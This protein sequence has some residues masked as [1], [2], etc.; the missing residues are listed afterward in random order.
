[1]I[2]ELLAILTAF[3]W[4]IGAI[5]ARKGLE[6]SN[7]TSATLIRLAIG[8]AIYWALII[9]FIPLD[10]FASEAVIYHIIAGVL[11]GF[12]GMQLSYI[13]M[14]RYGVSKSSTVLSTQSVF[15]SF[16]AVLILGEILT[17]PIGVGTILIILGVALLSF[18][19]NEKGGWL[20]RRLIFPLATAFFYGI[21][22][23]PTK[24]GVDITNSPILGATI[25]SSTSLIVIVLYIFL[26]KQKLSLNRQSFTY[27]SL[28]GV[29]GSI[30]FLCLLYAFSIGNLVTV[31][32]LFSISPLFTILLA[33]F[34]LGGLEKITVKLIVSAILV[35]IGSAII[36]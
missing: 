5:C 25:E 19:R 20:D 24:I 2:A 22:S 30:A 4:A 31:V 14:T 16:A 6:S 11:A 18:N 10:S 34:L 15:S 29:I 27:F 36:I 3:L 9:L 13:S 17:L 33:Y 1:M 7:A 12:I 26:S 8:F 21:A 23:I 28:G 35:V 32:P